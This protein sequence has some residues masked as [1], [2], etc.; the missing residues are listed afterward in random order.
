MLFLKPTS[1]RTLTAAAALLA[2]FTF[3]A[4]VLAQAPAKVTR[5]VVA[6]PPRRAGRLCGPHL[7]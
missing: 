3:A 7:G 2:A 5:L 1:R 4:P 6:F